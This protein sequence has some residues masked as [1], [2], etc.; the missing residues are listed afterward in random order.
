MQMV[1]GSRVSDHPLLL[2]IS[3]PRL[4][5]LAKYRKKNLIDWGRR[6][7]SI[8]DAVLEKAVEKCD[9]LGTFRIASAESVVVRRRFRLVSSI[10]VAKLSVFTSSRRSFY[11]I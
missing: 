3:A 10:F 11:W 1:F 6:R 8:C 9:S 4:A 7:Q 5:D 2:G